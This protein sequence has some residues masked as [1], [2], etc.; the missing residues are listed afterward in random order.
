MKALHVVETQDPEAPPSARLRLV[1]VPRPEPEPG[2]VVIRMEAAPANPSDLAYLV[3]RYG[4]PTRYGEGV[5]F[6][7][8]GTVVSARAGLLGRWLE[9]KRV[10]CAGVGR[11]GT[12]AEFF[13][14]SAKACLPIDRSIDAAQAATFLINPFTALGL[15]DR[16]RKVGTAA[17][18]QNAGASQVGRLVIRLAAMRGV[19]VIS[20]VRRAEQAED[21]RAI[22][23]EHVLV[24]SAAGYVDRLRGLAERLDARVAFDAVAGEDTARLLEAMPDRSLA[25]VY[26]GLSMTPDDPYGGV[27]PV[28]GL[29]FSG[30]RIEGF[31]LTTSLARLGPLRILAR[32][33]YLQRLVRE[34]ALETTIQSSSG[35]EDYPE[36]L[37][38]YWA[39]MSAG[40]AIL[41]L[42]RNRETD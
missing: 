9:G 39:D 42:E 15:L 41:E 34:G 6:E 33:R 31:W 35:I 8:C 7:G 37:D 21:L 1:E 27:Y 28:G 20:T 3:G 10:A 17:V 2:E 40:K 13:R 36:A 32:S 24:T 11:G 29:I 22:G 12:W 30:H 14:T 38:A 5:G 16:A 26:G 23:A 19:P 25:I 4:V 18:I